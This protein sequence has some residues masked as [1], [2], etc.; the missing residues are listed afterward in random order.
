MQILIAP[1]KF[2]HS[3]S[4]F[5]V[6]K[7][8][9]E[10]LLL[11]SPKFSVQCLP[12]A[13][14]GDGLSD[15]L[16]YYLKPVK[17]KVKV[18]DPLF[19]EITSTFLL[20]EDGKTAFVEM[21]KASGLALLA[22]K[23]YNCRL[24]STYGTGQLV[25]AAVMAKTEKVI[26]GIGGSAT[27]DA[28]TGMA[29]ALGYRFLD[30]A[31]IAVEPIGEN[32]AKIMT[33]D[34]S[35]VISFSNISFEVACDVTNPL[36]GPNG[37]SRVYAKQKGASEE[38]IKFLEKGMKHFAGVAEKHFGIE[39]ETISGAGAAGGLGAGCL[40]FLNASLKSGIDL[41][42]EIAKAVHYVKSADVIITGEGKIDTQSLNGKVISGIG[43]LCEQ[44]QK[45][46]FAFCGVSELAP[47]QLRELHIEQAF[48]ISTTSQNLDEAHKKAYENLKVSARQFG[49]ALLN[50]G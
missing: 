6:C 28:G 14:G 26:I 49:E 2:K 47:E 1:D 13:D 32:L 39:L 24:T 11:A 41:V 40:A 45:R 7:A 27:N 8:I 48:A 37:A 19:R 3:L 4:S 42:L 20:S 10:G 35:E 5:D 33:I 29:A 21:A 30:S 15:V 34:D 36:T 44:Y 38:D 31:G 50:T 25:L 43:K 22:P 12:L 46:L 23:E 17:Q 16:E 18:K 9:E